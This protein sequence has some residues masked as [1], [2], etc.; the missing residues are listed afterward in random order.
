MDWRIVD[1]GPF[2]FHVLEGGSGDRLLF[3]HGFDAHP[4]ESEFLAELAKSRSV[5]AP[6]AVGYGSSEGFDH[7]DDVVDMALSFRALLNALDTGPVDVIGHSLGGMF[8]AELAAL[9]PHLV[10][11]LVLISPFGLWLDE[12]PVPDLFVLNPNDLADLSGVQQV[13]TNGASN[14]DRV[15]ATL[16]RAANLSVAGKFLW[17]IPDRGLRRRL[18]YIEAPTL[19]ARGSRDRLI[20]EAYSNA[21]A[22]LI[23]GART[24]SIDGAGHY[25]MNDNPVGFAARCLTFLDGGN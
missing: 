15:A 22:E 10:R 8:A 3:L 7:I 20:P 21:F 14:E 5:I 18:S 2:R 13:P 19:V 25:P 23:P 11:R 1:A 12:H 4:G 9:S 16:T 6:E 24:E 17:P